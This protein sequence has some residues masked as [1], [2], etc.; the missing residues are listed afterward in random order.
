MKKKIIKLPNKQRLKRNCPSYFIPGLISPHKISENFIL[1][2]NSL[3][4]VGR[5]LRDE[6]PPLIFSLRV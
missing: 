6:S 1:L 2:D 4:K 5:K 3:L